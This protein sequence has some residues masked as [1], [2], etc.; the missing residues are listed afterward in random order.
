MSGLIICVKYVIRCIIQVLKSD[1]KKTSPINTTITSSDK[2]WIINDKVY[3]LSK[4][5]SFHPGGKHLLLMN[6]G[7]DCTELFF[8]YHMASQKDITHQLSILSKYYIRD[9]K[10]HE[11]KTPFNWN[12][13]NYE[14]YVDFKSRIQKHFKH[15]SVNRNNSNSSTFL[16]HSNGRK[17]SFI[18]L[19]I[20]FCL[21][22]LLL[23]TYNY[24]FKQY[25]ITIPIL[26]LCHW[27]FSSS[28]L[29]NGTHYC[30]FKNPALN[31]IFGG[32]GGFYHVPN[33]QWEMQH[34]ISHHS[35]TNIN[36]LDIDLNHFLDSFRTCSKQ[37]YKNIYSKWKYFILIYMLF[38]S[39]GQIDCW[40]ANINRN[41]HRIMTPFWYKKGNTSTYV[42]VLYFMQCLWILFILPM[43]LLYT[44]GMNHFWKAFLFVILPRCGHGVL[45][46]IFSQVSHVQSDALKFESESDILSD[47]WIIHQVR[48]CV[49]YDIYSIFWNI[50][51][52]G[53]NNQLM[54][55]LCPAVHPC[56]YIQL[57]PVLDQFCRDYNLKRRVYPD[58][59]HTLK[60][61]FKH[62][63]NVNDY[64]NLKH[65]Q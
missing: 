46:Y 39:I 33:V 20:Y 19:I 49:D 15:K 29:H 22:I 17:A 37:K 60:A 14:M 11:I 35:Y 25:W 18:R 52:I 58:I 1:T 61:H 10:P 3:D 12:G 34:V 8:M 54:H 53:L 13:K 23:I 5:L 65:E 42:L 30:M 38:T 6:R 27:L 4:Y 41:I 44:F 31:F 36:G 51:S 62:L 26:S 2:E 24:W 32:L 56:H 40:A 47:S 64:S 16:L 28:L 55:H 9:A 43:L 63:G 48:S 7:R 50:M 59:F 57:Q 45:F 21:G